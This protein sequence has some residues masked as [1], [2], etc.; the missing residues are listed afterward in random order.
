MALDDVALSVTISIGLAEIVGRESFNNYLAAAD[1][2]LYLAKSYGRN[3]VYSETML[4]GTA[5]PM[6]WSRRSRAP[7]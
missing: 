2:L 3:R 1:Q 6:H 7:I 4:S 5:Q